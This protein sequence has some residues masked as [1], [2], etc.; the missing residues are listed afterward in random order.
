MSSPNEVAM[1]GNTLVAGGFLAVNEA[2]FTQQIAANWGED[3]FL[4]H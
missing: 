1:E 3:C 2:A 4:M